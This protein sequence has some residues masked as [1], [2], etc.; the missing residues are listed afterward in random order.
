[1]RDGCNITLWRIGI[2]DHV[3][4]HPVWHRKIVWAIGSNHRSTTPSARQCHP[5]CDPGET[6][7]V[8]HDRNP[9]SAHPTNNGLHVFDVLR[10]LRSIQQDIMPMS[11]VKIFDCLQLETLRFDALS[12]FNQFR[13]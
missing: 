7:I 13:L 3:P 1:M 10:T 6:E 11:R 2:I 4:N 5:P 12:Q 9:S 8:S